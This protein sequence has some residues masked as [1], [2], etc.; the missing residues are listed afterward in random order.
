M[1]AIIKQ[2]SETAYGVNEYVCDS[3]EGLSSLPPRCAPGSTAIVLE[4]G[5]TCIYMKN[6]KGEWVKI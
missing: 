6:T 3:I 1:Y 2:D 5:N 4:A